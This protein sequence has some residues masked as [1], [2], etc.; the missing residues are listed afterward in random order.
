[1]KLSEFRPHDYFQVDAH[2]QTADGQ[3]F[4]ARWQPSEACA[5]YLDA[6][7]RVINRALAE[8]VIA[9]VNNQPA[10]VQEVKQQQKKAVCAATL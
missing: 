9:R 5:P 6:D 8:N 10:M 3:C 4:T 1:M 7:G 2:L